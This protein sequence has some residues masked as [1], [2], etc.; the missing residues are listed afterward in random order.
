MYK[1][2]C[3]CGYSC[4]AKLLGKVCRGGVVVSGFDKI[5]LMSKDLDFPLKDKVKYEHY[6]LR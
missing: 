5:D 3:A 2:N 1:S 4:G 6:V